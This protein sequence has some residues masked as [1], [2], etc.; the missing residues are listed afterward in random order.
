M[1]TLRRSAGLVAAVTEGRSPP[2]WI[3]TGIDRNG[4]AAAARALSTGPLSDRF[5]LAISG[6][7]YL[8]L[9]R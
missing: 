9:P 4:V 8:P 3:I 7:H 1:T 6:G 2:T 5:A